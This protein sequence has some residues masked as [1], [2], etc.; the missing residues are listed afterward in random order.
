MELKK[1]FQYAMALMPAILCFLVWVLPQ[2]S[3]AVAKAYNKYE[4]VK[5]AKEMVVH[6]SFY[7]PAVTVLF[8]YANQPYAWVIVTLWFVILTRLA[9]GLSLRCKFLKNGE[10]HA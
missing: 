9:Y 10:T 3:K 8:G 2:L 7:G 6:G 1:A 5:L 4:A